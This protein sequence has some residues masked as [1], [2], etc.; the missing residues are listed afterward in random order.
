M[1]LSPYEN[2]VGMK[3]PETDYY[4]AYATDK[5]HSF[6]LV[7]LDEEGKPA[8][9]RKLEYQV[10]E[11]SWR[12]WWYHG[13]EDFSRY[14][15][16]EGIIPFKKGTVTTDSK[17]IG[18]IELNIPEEEY[19]RYLIRVTDENGHATGMTCYFDWPE[20][21]RT[22]RSNPDGA[23]ML[24]VNADKSDYEVGETCAV[25][26]PMNQESRALITIENGSEVLMKD[27]VT[28]SGDLGKFNFK[29]TKGMAPNIYVSVHLIQPHNANSNDAP[30]RLYGTLPLNITDPSTLLEPEMNL[31]ESIRPETTYTVEVSEKNNKSMTYTLAVVDEGLLALTRFKT[32]DPHS[33]F[34]VRQALGV[35]TWD[36]YD[37]VIGANASPVDRLLEIGGGA[38][39]ESS[40]KNRAN[41]FKPVVSFI[42]PFHLKEG[43]SVKHELFMP[44]Y[45]GEVRVMLVA[46]EDMAYG[47][48]EASV[49]VKKPLMLLATLPRVLGPNETVSL[50]VNVFAM[51]DNIKK[52]DLEIEYNDFFTCSKTK[53]TIS[54]DKPGDQIAPFELEVLPKTGVGK[55]RID[56]KSGSETAH[57]EIE[58]DV[59]NPNPVVQHYEESVLR[60]GEDWKTNFDLIGTEGTNELHLEVSYL[61]AMDLD[62]RMKQLLRYPHGCVEQTTS[63]A[64]PQIFL[65]KVVELDRKQKIRIEKNVNVAIKKLSMFQTSD[66]GFS[67]WPGNQES[68]E[69]G[70]SYAGHFLI[71]A[72]RQGYEFPSN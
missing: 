35:R 67:Y 56:A 41:R 58:L 60:A 72:E 26:F 49:K 31:P 40:D 20:Y 47:H 29:I 64:F 8:G 44:N 70:T 62:K 37:D 46:A 43:Q 1:P 10:Y 17:G 33:H 63:K 21:K 71:E 7:T 61:P 65:D 34:Y 68:N 5:D 51:E 12:W 6:E 4:Y 38:E 22:S 42:G 52:V 28:S 69:W 15:G 9:N 11:L 24:M 16:A 54:F 13:Y 25:S 36:I 3:A 55:V 23:T 50:P 18:E 66:G 30:M 39:G 53:Q 45:V 57:Y 19:G 59:R 14:T 48:A 2:Y 27:W 32:P